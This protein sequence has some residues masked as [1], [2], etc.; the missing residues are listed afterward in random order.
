[1]LCNI[2]KLN[3]QLQITF[4]LETIK[5]VKYNY[6]LINLHILQ[7]HHQEPHGAYRSTENS[8]FS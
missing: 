1:M 4:T 3:T 2:F 6:L 7:E 8:E 5:T